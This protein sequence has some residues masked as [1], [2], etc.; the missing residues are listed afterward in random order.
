MSHLLDWLFKYASYETR[1]DNS[2]VES[3]V[4]NSPATGNHVIRYTCS[5]SGCL[6]LNRLPHLLASEKDSWTSR[7]KTKNKTCQRADE[8]LGANG[9]PTKSLIVLGFGLYS[10]SQRRLSKLSINLGQPPSSTKGYK[11]LYMTPA[12]NYMFQLRLFFFSLH[13]FQNKM[14][15]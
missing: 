13:G 9:H 14:I 3:Q 5:L 11:R 8:L 15:K 6:R 1:H 7:K 10:D 12:V 2:A 4:R